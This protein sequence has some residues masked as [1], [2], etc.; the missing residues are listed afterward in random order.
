MY[1]FCY[2]SGCNDIIY[3]SQLMTTFL[4][5]FFFHFHACRFVCGMCKYVHACLHMHVGICVGG[6]VCTCGGLHLMSSC[7]SLLINSCTLFA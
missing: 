3:G 1:G 5:V 2:F 4:P 6:Y 7:L